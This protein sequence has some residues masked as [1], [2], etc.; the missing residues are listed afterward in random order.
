MFVILH[1][2]KLLALKLGR[3]RSATQLSVPIDLFLPGSGLLLNGWIF[4]HW[5]LFTS[6]SVK[7]I[8][9]EGVDSSD[10]DEYRGHGR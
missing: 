10:F 4:R 1:L 3:R 5:L 7:F 9:A 2:F 6:F 8:F